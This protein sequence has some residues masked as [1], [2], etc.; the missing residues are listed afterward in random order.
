MILDIFRDFLQLAAFADDH[1]L[2]LA[3]FED[4]SAHLF[5]LFHPGFQWFPNRF[6][7]FLFGKRVRFCIF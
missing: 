1:N 4:R 7:Q 6:A 5:N 3:R 2:R